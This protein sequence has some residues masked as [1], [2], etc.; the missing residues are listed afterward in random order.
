MA[1]FKVRTGS[2]D[3]FHY[4]PKREESLIYNTE[5]STASGSI[6]GI[7]FLQNRVSLSTGTGHISC[8]IAMTDSLTA[9][10][11]TKSE[12][13]NTHIT[14]ASEKKGKKLGLTSEHQSSTGDIRLS[15]PEE[16]L[17]LVQVSTQGRSVVAVAGLEI[18]H[19]PGA[20]RGQ[21][22]ELKE[23]APEIV[24]WTEEMIGGCRSGGIQFKSE[25]EEEGAGQ[26]KDN[27]LYQI[28]RILFGELKTLT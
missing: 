3:I 9:R 8:T 5:V 24:Q 16:V 20:D 28:S 26:S 19:K 1:T 10:L 12:K 14:F 2:G 6:S 13:G 22:K 11:V 15:Y 27:I 17:G 23:Q 25:N 18:I 7:Y 21:I 4:S